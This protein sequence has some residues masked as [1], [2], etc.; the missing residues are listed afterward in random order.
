M[1]RN[2]SVGYT[3]FKST[4]VK[5]RIT[6][7]DLT[8]KQVTGVVLYN[9][10]IYMTVLVDLLTDTVS[11]EGSIDELDGLAMDYDSYIEMFKSQAAFFVANQISNPKKYYDELT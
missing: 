7:V 6:K 1:K 5:D 8:K 10:I 2:V 4:G 3:V 11:V 9:E